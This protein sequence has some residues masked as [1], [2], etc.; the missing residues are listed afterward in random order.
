MK[1]VFFY[2]LLLLLATGCPPEQPTEKVLEIKYNE[3]VEVTGEQ[4]KL[5]FSGVNDSRCPK[6]VQCITAGEAK[7]MIVVD[8]GS[9]S[10]NIELTAKGL[11]YEEDGSCGSEATAMGYKFKL[12]SLAPYPEQNAM[13]APEDYMVKVEFSVFQTN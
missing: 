8:Q 3:T 13:P 9:G 5:T 7:V 6:D 11:C 1:Q 2:G 10:E 4:M 12:L